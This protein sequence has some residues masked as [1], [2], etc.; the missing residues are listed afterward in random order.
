MPRRHIS[1]L[2]KIGAL[3]ESNLSLYYPRVRDRDDVEVLRDNKTEVI[4]LSRSDQTVGGYYEERVEKSSQ[5]VYGRELST[6][7]LSDNIRRAEDFGSYIR[8]KRWVDFGCGLGGML[9]ELGPQA[10]WAA[11]LEPNQQRAEIVRSKGHDVISSIEEVPE[12]SLDIITM[13]HVLEHISEP[14]KVLIALKSRLKPG[15]RLLVEVPHARDVLFTLYDSEAFKK[16]T[17]WSEHLVLHTRQSL[18]LLLNQAGYS[19]SEITG[20]QR[21]PLANHLYWL[22]QGKPA[23]HEIWSFLDRQNL[24]QEYTSILASIDRTDTLISVC[25]A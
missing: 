14:T 8:N 11:G 24:H 7:R 13:F 12:K 21:Y 16:F 15:G 17:F 22:S 3:E 20:Y 9:D 23:G 19:N 18:R 25:S 2:V 6:P 1:E 4:V 5:K 10:Q